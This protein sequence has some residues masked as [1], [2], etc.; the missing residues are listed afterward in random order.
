[1]ETYEN[2]YFLLQTS[3]AAVKA[4]DESE[5]IIKVALGSMLEILK[6]TPF[7]ELTVSDILWGYENSLI[8]LAKGIFP[9]DKAYPFE[10]FGLF[11][12]KNDTYPGILTTMTGQ[13]SVE[14]VGRVVS[15]NGE[16]K[17]DFWKDECNQIKGTD[18]SSFPPGILPN[19]TLYL[20]NRD[21]CRSLPL[22]YEADTVSQ[23]V[24]GYRFV[25]PK[26]IFSPPEE[27]PDNACYCMNEAGCKVPRGVFNM[28]ACSFGSPVMISWPHFFQADPK[29]LEDVVG[30]K[31][32][33][34]KHQLF[35]DIQPKLGIPLVAQARS[36]INI[37]MYKMDEVKPAEGLRD[38]IFPFMWFSS[39]IE[40]IEDEDTLAL[41][42]TAVHAPEKARSAL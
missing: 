42:H 2:I 38:M 1:M 17:L 16:T 5:N 23:G 26:D 21:L 41:L 31:P 4:V 35:M 34:S 6:Q 22:V 7:V 25:P 40:S 8:Q 12:G 3:L 30:L 14:D 39:G 18:G 11:A 10:K 9:E 24:P 29:L 27:N 32:E 20:F 13:S 37:Q 28:S 19:T 36:Q 15:W 33:Q